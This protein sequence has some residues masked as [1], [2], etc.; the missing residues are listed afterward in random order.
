[1]SRGKGP[2]PAGVYM[3]KGSWPPGPA[4]VISSTWATAAGVPSIVLAFMK[5]LRTEGVTEQPTASRIT[6]K[7]LMVRYLARCLIEHSL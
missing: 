2:V 7:K 6:I 4:M 5:I 1:M 3:R